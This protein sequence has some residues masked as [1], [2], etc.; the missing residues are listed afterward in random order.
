MLTLIS[1]TSNT[2]TNF[3]TNHDY[4]LDGGIAAT[5]EGRGEE[6]LM[7]YLLWQTKFDENPAEIFE[8]SIELF[9]SQQSKSPLTLI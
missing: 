1:N 3:A 2:N 9:L 5:N 6:L 7:E 4:V 8:D